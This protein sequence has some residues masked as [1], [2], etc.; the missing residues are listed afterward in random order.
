MTSTS[1]PFGYNA[2]GTTN[3]REREV[4]R[5]VFEKHLEYYFH[6]PQELIDEA[7]EWA[8]SEGISLNDE[9]AEDMARLR[10]GAYIAAQVKERF[11]DVQYR[12][13]A[14]TT[15]NYPTGLKYPSRSFRSEEI[16]DKDLYAQVQTIMS[17][18]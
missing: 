14:P 10:I 9:E 6:P 18:G 2:D 16:I 1:R 12:K 7:H 4:V 13:A 8:T 5:F 15:G 3:E 11:P 17:H